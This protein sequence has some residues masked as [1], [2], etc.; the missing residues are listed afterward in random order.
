MK[1][2]Y[3]SRMEVRMKRERP[4]REGKYCR[5]FRI[6]HTLSTQPQTMSQVRLP[7][8]LPTRLKF[9]PQLPGNIL[10]P[11]SVRSPGRITSR[12]GRSGETHR[13]NHQSFSLELPLPDPFRPIL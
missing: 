13:H 11:L 3:W 1:P 9:L 10:Y 8:R 6:L 4:V 5:T 12:Y 2:R 7:L